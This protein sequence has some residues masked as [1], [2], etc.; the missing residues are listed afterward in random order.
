MSL[1]QLLQVQQQE[2]DTRLF[3]KS[4]GKWALTHTLNL[5]EKFV[6]PSFILLTLAPDPDGPL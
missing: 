6:S 5:T 4:L 3:L 1:P 2:F